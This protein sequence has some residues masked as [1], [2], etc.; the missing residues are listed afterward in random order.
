MSTRAAAAVA[1]LLL[2]TAVSAG[3]EGTVHAQGVRGTATTTAR[4][5][6]LRPIV[7]DTVP[8]GLATQRP[9]GSF[10]YQGRPVT[11]LTGLGCVF[12]RS[13]DIEHAV[14]ATQ[15]VGFT[16]WGWGVQ[17]LSFTA[18]LRARAALGGELA[19]PRSGDPFDAVLAYGELNRGDF[20]TRVGRQRTASSLGFTGYDGANLLWAGIDRLAIEVYGG[21]SLMRGLNEPR[22]E[23]L[24]PV[25]EFAMDTLVTWLIGSAARY[26]PVRGTVIGARYQR[27]IWQNRAGLVSERASLEFATAQYRPVMVD[28]AIDYDFAFGRIGRAHATLRAPFRAD[29]TVEATARR[30]MPYFQLNT[31][32]GFFSPVGYHEAEARAT[33]RPHPA[34]SVW[35][36]VAWRRYE[37]TDAAVIFRPLARSGSHLAAGAAW[38]ASSALAVDGAYRLE[39]GFGAFVSSGDASLAWRPVPRLELSADLTAFQQIEQFRVGEGIVIGGGASADVALTGTLGL[40]GGAMLYRQ[41]FRN[42]PSMEDW[43]QRRGWA[44]LRAAFGSDPGARRRGAR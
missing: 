30:Y 31:I 25:Q 20:R 7:Q 22:A 9:D 33:W 29:L 17:G 21:R 41:T 19:W 35:A 5:V 23:A 34:G 3:P 13:A 28:A 4:Y 16:T 10:E 15:D 12:Y 39:R 40:S 32:W 36:S 26:E 43:N 1:L 24:R 8:A 27:E 14:I 37:E 38:R 6:E 18:L 11:C 2:G 42:R 44:A